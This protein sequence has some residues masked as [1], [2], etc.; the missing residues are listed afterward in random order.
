MSQSQYCRPNDSHAKLDTTALYT[1]VATKTIS[2]VMSPLEHIALKLKE[3]RPP[4]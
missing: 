1:R 3:I 2:E 4:G